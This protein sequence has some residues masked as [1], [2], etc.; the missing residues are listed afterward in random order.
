MVPVSPQYLTTLLRYSCTQFSLVLYCMNTNER[1][2]MD[3]L[4]TWKQTMEMLDLANLAMSK[5]DTKD[6]Q[7]GRLQGLITIAMSKLSDSQLEAMQDTFS[8]LI[9]SLELKE[10][11]SLKRKGK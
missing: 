10:K 7:I 5:K 11:K 3:N 4:A 2:D 9:R 1:D 8:A 6:E